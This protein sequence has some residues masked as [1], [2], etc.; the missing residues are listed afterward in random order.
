M[1]TAGI[2]LH[3]A[4]TYNVTYHGSAWALKDTQS[5]DI[6]TDFIVLL[7]HSFRMPIFFLL[8]GFFGAMLF[9]RKGFMAMVKHRIKRILYPFL[10][11]L[12][13]LSPLIQIAFTYSYS[14]LENNMDRNTI[15]LDWNVLIPQSTSHL[16]FLHYL[17]LITL[18]IVSIALILR[19]LPY[20]TI[21]LSKTFEFILKS[22]V[23]RVI[24]LSISTIF[25]LS[26]LGRSMVDASMSFVPDVATFLYFSQFYLVGWLLYL[27]RR[28]LDSLKQYAW[29]QL[30][31][32][33]LL[34][35]AKG[36][37]LQYSSLGYTPHSNVFILKFLSSLITWSFTFGIIG[38]FIQYSSSYSPK[39]KYLSDASYWIYL[40]H[41]PMALLLPGLLHSYSLP[42]LVKFFIV[43]TITLLFSIVSY[44]YCV[45]NTL[46]GQ[47]LNGKRF[48]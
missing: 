9:Y 14:R 25:I 37:T 21:P 19:S 5:T 44:H 20:F 18:T 40:I 8:S 36:L 47:F 42:V 30:I 26:I 28:Y 22:P 12:L 23:Y 2:F 31:L 34:T 3:S 15:L 4:L 17:I 7:V 41:L 29:L 32:A 35:I 13:L 48:K 45:R 24:F 11:S 33:V 39:M 6:S 1:M 43:S 46:I 27:N 38:L 16:W 10:L